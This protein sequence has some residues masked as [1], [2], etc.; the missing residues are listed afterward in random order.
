MD[1][2]KLINMLNELNEALNENFPSA[3]EYSEAIQLAEQAVKMLQQYKAIGTV[4]ECRIAV[5]KYNHGMKNL[6]RKLLLEGVDYDKIEQELTDSVLEYT[7]KINVFLQKEY[8]V[9]VRDFIAKKYMEQHGWK[10]A[11]HITSTENGERPG[12][13]VF[14]FSNTELPED[15]A[16]RKNSHKVLI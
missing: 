3:D 12:L 15:D 13:T 7:N 16:D 5:K 14:T 4:E 6:E 10:Y 9:N 11:Y 8:P 1:D 2:K